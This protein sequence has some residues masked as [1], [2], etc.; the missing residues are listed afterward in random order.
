MLSAFRAAIAFAALIVVS[1]VTPSDARAQTRTSYATENQVLSPE[2]SDVKIPVEA[3][4]NS[5]DVWQDGNTTVT[6]LKAGPNAKGLAAVR[7]GDVEMF[8]ESLVIIDTQTAGGHNVQIYAEGRVRYRSR[9]QQRNVEAHSIL[10]RSLQPVDI[11]TKFANEKT[12]SN[13][14]HLMMKALA[15]FDP[16]RSAA[17]SPVSL[18]AEPDSFIPPQLQA[19]QDP[20]AG[21]T[22]RI[23]IYPRS[24]EPLR[25]E[26]GPSRDTVPKEQVYIITGGVKVVVE[27]VMS[28]LGGGVM[29]P[30][31]LDLS[32]DRV[33]VWAQ[34]DGGP[35]ID[36]SQVFEQPCLLY[37]SPSPRD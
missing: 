21:Q 37:T 18:Q 11:R 19:V 7:Q 31:V 30:G 5:K 9:G 27:G 20:A 35:D 17:V 33:V 4:A 12:R 6:L 16:T 15:H 13:P 32:A 34:T 1:Q 26:S 14:T 36:I 29:Q 22:R 24:T 23:Q 28:D 8:A 25:F 10:L 3:V 2:T